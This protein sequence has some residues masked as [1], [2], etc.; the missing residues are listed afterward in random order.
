[1]TQLIGTI[2]LLLAICVALPVVAQAAEAAVPALSFCLLALFLLW[3][4]QRR[5]RG[6]GGW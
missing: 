2:A 6:G 5:A 3:A 4:L 1:V